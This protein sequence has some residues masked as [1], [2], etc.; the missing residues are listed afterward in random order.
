[1]LVDLATGADLLLTH[2]MP[3]T[4]R[5]AVLAEARSAYAGELALAACGTSYTV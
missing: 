2:L 5:G 1:V 4:D 3:F